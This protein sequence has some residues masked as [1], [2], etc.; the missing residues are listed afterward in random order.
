MKP[1]EHN[2][3]WASPRPL[4]RGATAARPQLLRFAHDDFME[5]IIHIADTDPARIADLV[6]K[7]ETWRDPPSPVDPSADAAAHLPL[8]AALR[9]NRRQRLSAR[10]AAPLP[11]PPAQPLKLWQPAHQRYYLVTG[12]LACAIPGLPEHRLAGSH[13]KIGFVLRRMLAGHEHAFIAADQRWVRVAEGLAPGEELLPLFPLRHPDIGAEPGGVMRTLHAGLVPVG[14]REAYL[15]ASVSSAAPISL[16]AGQAAALNPAPPPAPSPSVMG[17]LT[18]LRLTVIEPWKAMVAAARR[19]AADIADAE[20]NSTTRNRRAFAANLDFQMQ[21]W[22]LIL[23]LKRWIAAHLPALAAHI[24]NGTTPPP[25]TAAHAIHNWLAAAVPG[26][27]LGAALS[28]PGRA[29]A[30]HKPLADHLLAALQSLTP[31]AATLLETATTHYTRDE[32]RDEALRPAVQKRWP[33]FHLPLAGVSRGGAAVGPWQIAPNPLPG[34]AEIADLFAPPGAA[35][36]EKLLITDPADAGA[37]LDAIA[38]LFARALTPQVAE[39]APPLPH[40]MKLR[41]MAVKTAGD[42]GNFVIRMVHLNEDCGPLH[43]PTLSAA[44]QQFQLGSFFDPDAPVRPLTITLPSDT[45]PAGLRKHGRGTAFVMSDMLCGQVARAKG[46]GLIDL[47][48]HVLPFPLHKE[49]DVGDGGGCK[50]GTGMEI[51]MICSIS[52]PIITLCALILLMIMVTLLDF[53]FRWVPWFIA[54]FPVPKLKGKSS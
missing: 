6:A 29:N 17:R 2:L 49:L 41:D 35:P 45:S 23:D 4:W 18:D 9:A 24:T 38:A 47:I 19:T 48:R 34:A 3:A 33:G 14:R 22:L 1:L 16:A 25:G 46:L 36:D 27:S 10:S 15:A 11:L 54:C 12:S 5:R 8:P 39:A 43:P 40:A 31:A 51:G 30:Q 44:T 26:A 37:A 42:P 50:G 13:E 21:S 32:A 7:P 52:I 28:D 53:I 20:N